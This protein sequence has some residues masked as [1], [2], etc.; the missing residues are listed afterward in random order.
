MAGALMLKKNILTSALETAIGYNFRNP[1]LLTAALS[2]SSL[3]Q[4]E[5]SLQHERLEFLGDAVLNLAVARHLYR[6]YPHAREGDLSKMRAIIVSRPSLARQAQAIG[7]GPHLRLG[8]GQEQTHGRHNATIL[9]DS[10]ESLFGAVCLDSSFGICAGVIGRVV[11]TGLEAVV[12]QENFKNYKSLLQ[13]YAQ[14]V[15]G[16]KPVY[17]VVS[18]QGL[19]HARTFVVRVKVNERIMGQGTGKNKKEAEQRAARA[20]LEKK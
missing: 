18:A 15:K 7:L 8:K 17:E 10:L 1:G 5:S 14:K 19:D 6:Q 12:R 4:Q 3:D 9:A 16:V 20:A 11:L 2:H 13:E